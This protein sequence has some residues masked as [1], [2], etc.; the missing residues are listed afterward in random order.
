MLKPL[1]SRSE[2]EQ[3]C[4]A[5][6]ELLTKEE[7]DS[8]PAHNI[9]NWMESHAFYLPAEVCNEANE[10]AAKIVEARK[11]AGVIYFNRPLLEP[12]PQMNDSFFK[13]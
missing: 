5:L 7:F 9:L 12:N 10:L 6:K 13:D 8:S 11:A 3:K 4:A 1:L 2:Y